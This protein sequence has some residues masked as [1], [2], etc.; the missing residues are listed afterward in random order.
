VRLRAGLDAV[1]KKYFP[2]LTGIESLLLKRQPSGFV[3]V[4]W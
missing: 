2:P 1:K 4:R 3:T